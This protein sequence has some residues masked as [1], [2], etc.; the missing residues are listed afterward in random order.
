MTNSDGGADRDEKEGKGGAMISRHL[1]K[2][3][4]MTIGIA[5]ASLVAGCETLGGAK[6][7]EI[8][9]DPPGALVRVE[10][11]GECTSPCTVEFDAPRT[12]TIAKEGYKAQ[13]LQLKPGKSRAEFK[14]EL[15]APVTDVEAGEVPDL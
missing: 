4:V 11:F 12:I 14:L 9:T 15:A 6:L 3:S 1:L 7:T 5:G 10:G 2:A 8:V 13:R